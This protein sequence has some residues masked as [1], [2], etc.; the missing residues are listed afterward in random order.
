MIHPRVD[1]LTSEPNPGKWPGPR[2]ETTVDVEVI[3]SHIGNI[4]WERYHGILRDGNIAIYSQHPVG[5]VFHEKIAINED[6]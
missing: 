1:T 4:E 6:L 2:T 3:S 5:D